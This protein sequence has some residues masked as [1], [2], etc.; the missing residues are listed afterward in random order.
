LSRHHYGA[1]IHDYIAH[2]YRTIAL[3]N[4]LVRVE[5]VVDKGSDVTSFLHKPTDTDF[6]WHR[7]SGLRRAPLESTP[8]GIDEFVFFDGYEGGWQE[9]FPNGGE[10]VLY[11]GARLPFH[12]ELLAAP[13]SVEVLED[14]PQVVSIRLAVRTMRTPFL[15]E[16]RLTLRSGGG[17]LEIDERLVNL[18]DEPMEVMWGHHPAF[19]PPFL[20]DSCRIDLP[21]CIATTD[22]AEPWPD[23]HLAYGVEFP[24]PMAP[25]KD[26]TLR[27]LSVVPDPGSRIAD[28][29]R[30]TGFDE[31]W[32][33]VTNRRRRVGFGLRW[34]ARLFRHL[35]FWHVFGG[36]PGYPWYGLNYNFALEPWTSYPDGGLTRAIENGSALRVGAR[37]TI[38][39][40]ILAIAYVGSEGIK[41]IDENGAIAR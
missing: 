41:G 12:G 18:A 24:W 30:L 17:V 2:G 20:D 5:V 10:S 19:G 33:G 4:E 26:G 36:M 15:I 1:R 16:K 6:M 39:T 3:E 25:R 21:P 7:E 14:S 29:V 13:W 40:R 22:R 35:W 9:C 23:S 37:E 31:G 8:R 38:E 11:K 28:W 34:D 32:Y 27:D